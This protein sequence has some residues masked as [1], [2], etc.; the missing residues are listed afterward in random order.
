MKQ[1]LYALAILSLCGGSLVA[2]DWGS[3][4]PPG[5][6]DFGACGMECVQT[7]TEAATACRER[8]GGFVECAQ[9]FMDALNECRAGCERPAICGEECL[10][11]ARDAAETCHEAGGDVAACFLALKD[12]LKACLEAAGCDV[13]A[14]PAAQLPC[15]ATC[16]REAM[17]AARD[18]LKGGGDFLA[19]AGTFQDA[20]EACRASAGCSGGDV[21]PPPDGEMLKV[22][23]EKAFV[24]G[25]FNEDRI[26]DISDAVGVL[27]HLFLGNVSP[28]CA[29]LADANDDGV[30][31]ISDAI[32]LLTVLFL[33]TGSIRAPF[34][35][36][37]FDPTDDASIC[38]VP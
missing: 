29:D 33:G 19:C 17:S 12:Q 15:G 9:A 28:E 38:G 4:V 32:D 11:A 25:D 20:L 24:R 30:I 8:G 27:M 10:A 18:C 21:Q 26:V 5:F 1:P 31:D 3:L 36:E 22:I 6:E 13:P 7:A 34:P 2:Q 23:L 16:I 35:L 37:G 14:P